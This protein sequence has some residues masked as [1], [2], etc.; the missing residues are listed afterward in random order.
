MFKK[1]ILQILNWIHPY[2][3]EKISLLEK[4]KQLESEKSKILGLTIKL[5][6]EYEEI[7]EGIKKQIFD[8][9]QLFDNALHVKVRL[10]DS[11]KKFKNM[12]LN[13]KNGKNKGPGFSNLRTKIQTK[14][15]FIAS[16]SQSQVSLNRM[17][18][19]QKIF[20]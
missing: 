18:Q 4:I 10:E 9:T 7:F 15:I 13:Q 3:T 2:K 17:L 11:S 19:S 6:L 8:L 16:T 1:K 12:I 5:N 14:P 20:K